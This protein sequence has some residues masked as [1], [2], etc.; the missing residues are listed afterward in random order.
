[1]IPRSITTE[2]FPSTGKWRAS[3]DILQ[4]SLQYAHGQYIIFLYLTSYL[5]VYNSRLLVFSGKICWED[6]TYFL[7]TCFP[8]PIHL[9]LHRVLGNLE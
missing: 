3:V 8:H 9:A 7:C 6:I 5:E 2:V 4:A 1:M